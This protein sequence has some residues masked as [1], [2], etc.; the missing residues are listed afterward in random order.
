METHCNR[1]WCW[2]PLLE[3]NQ[4]GYFSKQEF[5]TPF[6]GV[7][8]RLYGLSDEEFLSFK[9]SKP[10]YNYHEEALHVLEETYDMSTDDKKKAEIEFFDSKFTSL[11]PLQIEWSLAN[12]LSTFDFWF[13]DM[14]LVVAMYDSIL[15]VWRQKL[16]YD[17]VRPTTVVHSLMEGN[18]IVS[19]AGPYEGSKQMKASDWQPYIRTMPVSTCIPNLSF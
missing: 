18:D 8:A 11:L 4:A 14:T 2:E 19:Y 10:N 16:K 6:I 3:S 1:R 15:V 17:A 5:V 7:T 12:H 9:V 13:Y